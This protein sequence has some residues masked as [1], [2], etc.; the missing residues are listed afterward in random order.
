M[1]SEE[2]LRNGRGH[3]ASWIPSLFGAEEIPAAIVTYVSL[4]MFLQADTSPALSTLYCGCLFLPWVLKSFYRERVRRIGHFR[5]Q[6]QWTELAMVMTLVSIALVFARYTIAGEWLFLS[7]FVLSFLTAWHELAARMYYER[8]LY[9]E[10]QRLWNGPK[11]FFSQVAVVFTYGLVIMLVGAL[12][13][14]YRRMSMAWSEGCYIV[15]GVFLLFA[16][17][18]IV[19]LR[20]PRV[21]DAHYPGSTFGAVKAEVRALE[22]IRQKKHWLLAVVMLVMALLPQGLMFYTR[23]IFLLTPALEGGLGCTIQDVAFAQGT[24]GVIGFSVGIA[25][26]RQLTGWLSSERV[27]WWLTIPLGLSPC[28]YVALTFAPPS[29]LWLLSLA[30]FHAQF[31]FGFGLPICNHFVRYIS[32]ERY[33]NT[34]NYLYIPLVALSLVVPISL[35][36]WLIG[37]LG[38]RLFFIVDAAL[39]PVAWMLLYVTRVDKKL[40]TNDVKTI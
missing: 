6:I 9:P 25:L 20:R 36:G 11:M 16:V 14:I 15:A 18:H 39:A 12:Q 29:S 28:V 33:R 22:R 8:M 7:L 34:I 35:S 24:V 40:K 19:V 37:I 38:F 3:G 32:G 5:R 13:V 23:V 27:F 17:Y 4:L 2:S 21:G 26:G 31:L 30:T 10:E 1:R